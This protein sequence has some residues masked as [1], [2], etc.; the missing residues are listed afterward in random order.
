MRLGFEVARRGGT[1]GAVL[2]AANEA[3]VEAFRAE[4]I[5]FNQIVE[6]V[7]ICLNNHNY[8]EKPDLQQLMEADIWARSQVDKQLPILGRPAGL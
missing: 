1:A 2:N 4:K 7:E 5:A 6:L 8:I 3:A